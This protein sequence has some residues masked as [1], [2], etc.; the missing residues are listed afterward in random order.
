MQKTSA[1]LIAAPASGSGK[2]TLTLGL[3]RALK[4]REYRCQPFKCGPDYIDTKF[5]DLASGN[6]SVNLDLFLS[7][8]AHVKS[9]FKKYGQEQEVRVIEGVMGLFDGYERMNGSSAQIA[10]LLDVPVVLVVDARSM[11]YSAAALL[12]GYKHFDKKINVVGVIF[13]FTGSENHRRF[14]KEACEDVGLEV[15]GFLPKAANIEI[16]SRHLGLNLDKEYV[17]DA[18]AEKAASLI[19]ECVDL[20]KLLS[21]TQRETEVFTQEKQSGGR[22]K[23]A[24]ASD[25]AFNF[26]YYENRKS[27]ERLG[28]VS[29][30]SPLKDNH[31]PE[32]D[33]IYFPGGYPELFL[34]ELSGNKSLL[35]DIRNYVEKEGKL[36]AECGGMMYLSSSITDKEGIEY[37]MAGIFRQKASMAQMKLTLGYRQFEYNGV[38]FRGHEFHYSSVEDAPESIT[39][40]YDARNRPVETKLLRYKNA[41]GGYTHIYWAEKNQLMDLFT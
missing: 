31:L 13:N 36:F 35:E 12:Y 28:T 11:A 18:F 10:A 25:E 38:H 7:S 6:P 21:L 4:N 14:L 16:P 19:E 23:I 27:L 39:Q 20:E 26:M 32:A 5:H 33:F 9:L 40:Q 41:L 17:F 30:F 34:E 37:P 8:A 3:L 29:F 15:F 22:M 24:V 1:F 2:T